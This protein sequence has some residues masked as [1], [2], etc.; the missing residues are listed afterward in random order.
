MNDKLKLVSE[1]PPSVNHY[2]GY[3]AIMKK[4]KPVA[5]SYK[6]PEA[7]KYQKDFISYVK[8]EVKKQKWVYPVTK[9]QH[10]YVDSVFY[11]PRTDMDAN[12]YFKC[13]LDAITDTQ[14]VWADDNVV[15]ERVQGIYYDAENPR[16][17]L[18]IY[19]VEYIGIFKDS[20]QLE[21]FKANCIGCKRG[22]RNCSIARKAKE[23][24]IQP[25]IVDGV[26]NAYKKRK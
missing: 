21:N 5:V 17:E 2:L 20:S 22:T 18:T 10:F 16:I 19:P 9:E 26:C 6:T 4:G 7:K 13:L 12:N 25:E 1:I 8:Q 11:F 24:R 3:R 23:G 15:C 14:L